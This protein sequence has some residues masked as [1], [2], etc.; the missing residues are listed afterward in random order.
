METIKNLKS[1]VEM[2]RRTVAEEQA[3]KYAAYKKIVTLN[4]EIIKLKEEKTNEDSRI[5]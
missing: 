3:Q 2:L 5:F 4:E 1:D